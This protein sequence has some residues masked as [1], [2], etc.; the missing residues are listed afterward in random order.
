[1]LLIWLLSSG[2]RWDKALNMLQGI[3]LM[4]KTLDAVKLLDSTR[5]KR[6]FKIYLR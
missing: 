1:M 5:P 6:L 3:A 4:L 2:A